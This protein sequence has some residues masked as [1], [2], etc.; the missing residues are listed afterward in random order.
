MGP[1]PGLTP[2]PWLHVVTDDAVLARDTFAAMARRILETGGGRVALHVRG[3]RTSGATLFRLASALAPVAEASRS[4][5]VVNGRVDVALCAGLGAVHLGVRSLEPPETRS[6]LG[7]DA[8]IGVS[9]HDEA[10]ARR[11]RQLGADW[12]FAGTLWETPS[13]PARPGVGLGGLVR[14]V[15]A[16]GGMPVLGIGGVTPERAARLVEAG[17]HGVAVIRGV[18][19]APDPIG[20]M[21]DYLQGLASRP[22]ERR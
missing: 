16:A 4:L 19:D 21:N 20:A 9:T 11:A 6:I 14:S 17:G 12:I 15:A 5:L 2:L 3:P 8:R 18:W 1:D 22:A 7:E 13:H 10:E